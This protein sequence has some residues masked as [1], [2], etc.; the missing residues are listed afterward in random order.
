M[1]LY[2]PAAA[3][4]TD[5]GALD[6]LTDDD[7]TQ[8]QK[9]SEK[10]A[11]SGYASLDGSTKVPLAQLPTGTTSSTVALGDAAAALDA[12]HAAAA[13]PHT[14]Y[15][16][17]NDANW[18]DLTDAGETSLHS[19]AAGAGAPADADYL[20]GT[21]NAGLSA[22]IVVGTSPGGELGGPWAS[23]TVD[24]THA[25]SAHHSVEA[26]PVGSV[27]IAVVSTDPATLLGYGTWSAFGAGR[28]LVG[29]DAGQTEFDTVEETGGAKIVTLAEAEMP[30]HTH[31]LTEL[32]DA[33]TGAAST[34]IALAADTSSTL[35]TKVTGSR[36]GGGAHANLQPYIVCYF[37]KRTA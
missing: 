8:Y 25:G 11:A 17:E 28:V 21:A 10:A 30:A 15:V 29:L 16:K 13:D 4:V 20:V 18:V 7:H 1:P 6:G 27:F 9:E 22:E 14:G 19:H 24:A 12:T 33:T 3:G 31:V 26:F 37:W 32:R 35:G 5:H 23:P 2:N 34:N 36:G